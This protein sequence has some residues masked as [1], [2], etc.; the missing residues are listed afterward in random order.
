MTRTFIRQ[1]VRNPF[2]CAFGRIFGALMLASCSEAPAPA[3]AEITVP[4]PAATRAPAVAPPT[5]TAAEQGCVDDAAIAY[6]CGPQNAEDILRIGTTEWL[7]VSGMNGELANDS[8]INGK[9]HL[10]NHLDKSWEV[11][12]PGAAPVL[13]HDTMLFPGC[14]GPLDVSNFSAH[15]LAL[16]AVDSGPEQYRVYMTSH[17]AREAIEV[18]ELD[19]F[20]KPT[21]KWVG[22]VPMPASS[23]T[24][25]ITILADGGF[26]ATQFMD[27]T[28][29]GMAGVLAREITGHVFEWHPGGDVSVMAGTE[30]SGPNGIAISD[31][32]R[33]VYVAAFGTREVVRF[34]RS[35]NPAGK[36]SVEIDVAPD[37]IRWGEDNMLYTAGGNVTADCAGPDCGTGWS[38]IQ[39]VPFTMRA[40]RYAGVDQSA[41]MQG[42]SSALVVNDEIWIGTYSGDRLGILPKP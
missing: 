27:P 2:N 36:E 41:A 26:L 5:I 33:W 18:F 9:I 23:W 6:L 25:S 29:S 21:L 7:L 15:G 19:A 8:S 24:N 34:D 10:V 11:L 13:E 37:N 40:S 30:L 28:A 14:P 3:N 22:C 32:E 17:G 1:F 35:S 42:V 31:D 12:F 38:V 20:V 39:V 4:A 16:Q